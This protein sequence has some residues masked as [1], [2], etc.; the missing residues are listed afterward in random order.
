[1]VIKVLYSIFLGLL[2]V[3]FVAWLLA[4]LYPTPVWESE[5]P[6]IAEY[7]MAPEKPSAEQLQPLTRAEQRAKLQDYETKLKEY[8]A[9]EEQRE[10]LRAALHKKSEKRAMIVSLV[11]LVAA[12]VVTSLG[13]GLSRR[14][15]IISEGL[16]LGGLFTLI[17][18]IGWSFIRSPKIAVIPVGVGL[19]V[20]IVLG[21][22]RFVPKANR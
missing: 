1:M 14:L 17:Y 3:L 10:K 19:V 8:N 16:L 11:S 18:S 22:L 13:V 21:Y 6:D 15:P 4:A 5:Y 20:T 7:E 2:V 12:V 9:R